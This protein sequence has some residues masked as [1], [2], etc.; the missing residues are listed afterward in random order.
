MNHIE[1]KAEQIVGFY[2]DKEHKGR[3]QSSG[4]KGRLNRV[5]DTMGLCYANRD[6]PST[7]LLVEDAA[8]RGRGTRG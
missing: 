8:P 4:G 1:H 5:F 6:G 3:C 2:R 7:S